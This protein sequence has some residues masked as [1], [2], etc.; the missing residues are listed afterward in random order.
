MTSAAATMG[1][2]CSVSRV[3]RTAN[4]L[5]YPPTAVHKH[6]PG[7]KLA[8]SV[9]SEI[10]KTHQPFVKRTIMHIPN[11]YHASWSKAP[12]SASQWPMTTCMV[13]R[14]SEFTHIWLR[15]RSVLFDLLDLL[16]DTLRLII[17]QL[18]T[19]FLCVNRPL[20]PSGTCFQASE[21]GGVSEINDAPMRT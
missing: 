14:L 11:A 1:L 13:P 3:R 20:V 19:S 7:S 16:S 15:A 6:S 10:N 21:P 17:R 4:T 12:T 9:L 2:S 5:T 8:L 18:R